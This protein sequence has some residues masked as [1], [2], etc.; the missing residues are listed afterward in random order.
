MSK[1]DRK[2]QETIT[3]YRKGSRIEY[4]LPKESALEEKDDEYRERENTTLYEH[5]FRHWI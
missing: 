1:R 4:Q 5:M 3:D 2:L